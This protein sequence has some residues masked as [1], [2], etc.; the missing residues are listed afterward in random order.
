[1]KLN[2]LI[3]TILALAL[4]SSCTKLDEELRGQTGSGAL[5][6][7]N[8][9]ALLGGVYTSMRSPFQ[10]I[11]GWWS[12]QEVTS[13]E[14]LIPTRGGDWDDNGIYRALFLHVWQDDHVRVRDVY[15]NLHSVNYAAT[16]LLRFDPTASQAAQARFLRAFA[17]FSILD[18]WGQVAYRDPGEDVNEPSRVRDAQESIDYLVEE[19][20]TILP[21]LPDAPVTSATKDAAKMLLMKLFLNKGAFLNRQSPVFDNADM[22]QVVVLADEIIA[23][24]RFRLADNYY[25][26]FA[27]NNGSISVENVFTSANRGG[28]DGGGLRNIWMATLHYNQNPSGWNGLCTLGDFYDKFEDA[29]TR[30]GGEYQGVTNVSGLRVGFLFGQQY[31]QNNQPIVD[32]R[33]NPLSFRKEVNLIER[34]PNAMES[35]GVRVIKYPVDYA[36]NASGIVNNDWVYFRYSDVLLMKAEALLRMGQTAPAL[37]LVNEVRT[38]RGASVMTDLTLDTMLDELGREFFWEGRRRQDLIRFNKFLEPWQLKET[39]DP[40]AVLFPIPQTQMINPN[41]TQNPGY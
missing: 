29:D 22:Q 36:N 23:G 25:D 12:L 20:N 9:Q 35:A 3:G 34:D 8:A 19:I 1:M 41:Y 32:R 6:E 37:A 13:D 17:Q 14:T 26:N 15:R 30:R 11:D 24:N 31:D 7:D 16:D 28:E 39:D 38:N 5:S 33:G 10:G 40:R 4:T 27:S 21:D 2:Y 18:G